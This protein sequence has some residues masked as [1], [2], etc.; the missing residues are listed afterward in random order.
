MYL[1]DEEIYSE[2]FEILAESYIF[3]AHYRTGVKI[4]DC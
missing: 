1:G 4:P 3:N 2:I